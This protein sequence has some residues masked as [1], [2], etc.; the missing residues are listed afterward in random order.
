MKPENGDTGIALVD[1]AWETLYKGVDDFGTK[2]V[3][4]S[5]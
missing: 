4:S 2:L 3:S 1:P 5:C